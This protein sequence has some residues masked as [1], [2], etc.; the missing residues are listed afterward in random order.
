MEWIFSLFILLPHI[1]F[2]LIIWL[3]VVVVKKSTKPKTP[4][5]TQNELQQMAAKV[6][7]MKAGL[8]AWGNRTAADLTSNMSFRSQKGM[9][10]KLRG[11][12]YSTD[13][14]A[15]V[16]FYRIERGMVTTGHLIARTS[17][18]EVK[19][20]YKGTQFAVKYDNE[21]LG[22]IASNGHLLDANGTPIGMAKH[23][24]K[25]S[26]SVGGI[27]ARTG[28][29]T[30]EMVINNRQ[31]A[32]IRVAPDY[33]SRMSM[34]FSV[35]ENSGMAPVLQMHDTPTEHEEKWLRAL[36]ILETAYHGHFLV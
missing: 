7:E 17:D 31:L 6:E 9:S 30:F 27:R 5:E 1:G 3:I 16:A 22:Q 34:D 11:K 26:V 2:G 15:V 13:G 32:S 21:L 20:K 24:A 10:Q 14:E 35:N 25:M 8:A 36:A 29:K 12:I 23:P 33:S 18:F 28:S 19:F 4:Q